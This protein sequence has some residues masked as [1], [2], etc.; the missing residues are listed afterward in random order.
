VDIINTR[1]ISRGSR[2][3]RGFLI[4][5]MVVMSAYSHIS[6]TYSHSHCNS[7]DVN[8]DCQVWIRSGCNLLGVCAK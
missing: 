4:S 1:L 3:C 5:H 6:H 2:P 7:A 8:V